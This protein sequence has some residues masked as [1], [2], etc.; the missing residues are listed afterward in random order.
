VELTTCCVY[1]VIAGVSGVVHGAT[2]TAAAERHQRRG[3]EAA[4]LDEVAIQEVAASP[5]PGRDRREGLPERNE[6][7]RHRRRRRRVDDE[8]QQRPADPAFDGDHHRQ[9]GSVV[10]TRHCVAYPLRCVSTEA[11]AR[12]MLHSTKLDANRN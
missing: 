3:E 1:L 4:E 12:A 11:S 10:L 5:G 7:G 9:R 6:V 8:R 2:A